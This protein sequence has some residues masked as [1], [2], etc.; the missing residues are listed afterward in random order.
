MKNNMPPDQLD[1]EP[2]DENLPEFIEVTDVLDLHGFFPE[3]IPE[4]MEEFINHAQELG[5]VNLRVI[6]GKGKSKLKW[7]VHQVLKNHPR[8]IWFGDAPPAYGGWGATII[9]LKPE[10]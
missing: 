1:S 5:L 7:A 6:H 8:V 10:P 4:V 3:Q 2:D 9:E